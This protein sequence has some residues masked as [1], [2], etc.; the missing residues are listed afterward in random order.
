MTRLGVALALA[1]CAVPGAGTSDVIA[2]TSLDTADAALEEASAVA[3]H[4]VASPPPD[5]TADVLS[6]DGH[7]N[8]SYAPTPCTADGDCADVTLCQEAP[9][10][11]CAAAGSPEVFCVRLCDTTADCFSPGPL[12]IECQ[13][14]L[15]VPQNQKGL[16]QLCQTDADCEKCA[17]PGACICVSG[18]CESAYEG[19]ECGRDKDCACEGCTCQ[20]P[21]GV[22]Q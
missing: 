14:G 21:P 2:P 16:G 12:T 3:G 10:C 13:H 18:Q 9:G 1:A 6:Q 20:T 5:V 19:G 8:P 15:C 17:S 7:T 11:V 22:C 4:E